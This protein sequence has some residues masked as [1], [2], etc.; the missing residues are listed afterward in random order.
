MRARTFAVALATAVLG[1]AFMASVVLPESADPPS[2]AHAAGLRGYGVS[3]GPLSNGVAADVPLADSSSLRSQPWQDT[4]EIKG[5]G[6]PVLISGQ[7]REATE[8]SVAIDP[9][10]TQRIAVGAMNLSGPTTVAGC[11]VFVSHDAG[12]TWRM[13][14][15]LP[16]TDHGKAVCADPV[17]SFDADGQLHLVVLDI[18]GLSS[19]IT[20]WHLRSEDGGLTWAPPVRVPTIDPPD[21]FTAPDKPYVIAGPDGR[22]VVCQVQP[23]AEDGTALGV[24]TSDDDGDTWTAFLPHALRGWAGTCGTILQGS[25]SEL[26]M[27]FESLL[28]TKADFGTIAVTR[29][30]DFGSGWAEPEVA[31]F[32]ESVTF[33]PEVNMQGRAGRLPI[34]PQVPSTAY[35]PKTD[36]TYVAYG[37]AAEDKNRYEL[38]TRV[39]RRRGGAFT[40]APVITPPSKTC[41]LNMLDPFL[42]VNSRGMLGAVFTCRSSIYADEGA[43]EVWFTALP[44][45]SR[46]WL[47]PVRIVEESAPGCP[48]QRQPIFY[49]CQRYANDGDYWE[50]E[51]NGER[52]LLMW[53]EHPG[54]DR[55]GEIWGQYVEVND[56]SRRP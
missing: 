21:L 31:G 26:V 5:V 56:E 39:Q 18:D 40:D 49:S 37:T 32:Y 45:G 15:P 22:V 11:V 44:R 41:E 13:V 52:F 4:K 50:L 34:F 28:G 10:N 54:T 6:Q 47:E 51:S 36:T 53:I 2:T 27:M 23:T 16:I 3:P 7:G 43:R 29:S 35:D 12:A 46:R 33:P 55:K 30:A 42:A 14:D 20:T 8:F 38:V 9:E 25:G 48:P 17:V 24:A 19:M 1:M